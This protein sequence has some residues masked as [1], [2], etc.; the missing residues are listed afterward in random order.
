MKRHG[1]SRATREGQGETGRPETRAP[2]LNRGNRTYHQ[3]LSHKGTIMTRYTNIVDVLTDA[4]YR[5]D[6]DAV[7]RVDVTL[8][9]VEHVHISECDVCGGTGEYAVDADP[10]A[11]W[12]GYLVEC[13]TC[14]GRGY[15]HDTYGTGREGYV[16]SIVAALRR[17]V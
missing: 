4:D 11:G 12:R 5:A 7:L 9:E 13:G 6:A 14:D 2:E 1:G 17:L 3:L 15:V 16:A 10:S 8:D